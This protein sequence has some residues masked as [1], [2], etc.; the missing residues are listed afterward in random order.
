MAYDGSPDIV[1]GAPV[2]ETFAL[3][4]PDEVQSGGLTSTRGAN[5]KRMLATGRDLVKGMI[6]FSGIGTSE[7]YRDARTHYQSLTETTP[8][9]D[10]AIQRIFTDVKGRIME[11][12]LTEKSLDETYLTLMATKARTDASGGAELAMQK[13]F[14]DLNHAAYHKMFRKTVIWINMAQAFI[15]KLRGGQF[16]PSNPRDFQKAM[17]EAPAPKPEDTTGEMSNGMIPAVPAQSGGADDTPLQRLLD[18]VDDGLD[19]ALK[20]TV[21]R[22]PELER[23]LSEVPPAELEKAKADDPDLEQMIH[24]V[25]F[26]YELAPM[27]IELEIDDKFSGGGFFSRFTKKA[28][29]VYYPS[30][31]DED[32]DE[33]NPEDYSIEDDVTEDPELEGG[34]GFFRKLMGNARDNVKQVAPVKRFYG[35]NKTWGEDGRE[36][37]THY[38]LQ[39]NMRHD[40]I[41][42]I[43]ERAYSKWSPCF[44]ERKYVFKV[45]KKPEE[46]ETV[47][48]KLYEEK[49]SLMGSF[50]QGEFEYEEARKNGGFYTRPAKDGQPE[51]KVS[52]EEIRKELA[53]ALNDKNELYGF[54][55]NRMC[56]INDEVYHLEIMGGVKAPPKM[57][58]PQA[59]E[60]LDMIATF[61]KKLREAGITKKVTVKI[62][63]NGVDTGRTREEERDVFEGYQSL[64]GQ[65]SKDEYGQN[66]L[67]GG[68][69]FGK[70]RPDAIQVLLNAFVE[71]F[72]GVQRA[73]VI[74]FCPGKPVTWPGIWWLHDKFPVIGCTLKEGE[75]TTK[76]LINCIKIACPGCRIPWPPPNP[77]KGFTFC[78]PCECDCDA[79][80]EAINTLELA[81]WDRGDHLSGPNVDKF[82]KKMGIKPV[83][84]GALGNTGLMTQYPNAAAGI[85]MPTGQ[86]G[87][88]RPVGDMTQVLPAPA[89]WQPGQQSTNLPH[90]SGNRPGDAQA[91]Y[92][93]LGAPPAV[94]PSG[95]PHFSGNRP[96]DVQ[97]PYLALGQA[98]APLTLK[99][100]AEA[101]I[102]P[103]RIQT[104]PLSGT[105]PL[106]QRP[107]AAAGIDPNRAE[108][109][110]A[111]DAN[112]YI[113]QT[114]PLPSTAELGLAGTAP[115]PAANEL[116]VNTAPADP[117][118]TMVPMNAPFNTAPNPSRPVPSGSLRDIA[119]SQFGGASKGSMTATSIAL[120]A[121]ILA[122]AFLG[123]A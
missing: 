121:T 98:T 90:F 62:M 41:R 8:S 61:Q 17:A 44:P 6:P 53:S 99:P 60:Y 37:T 34:A 33:V 112:G 11:L 43:N 114:L 119:E 21:D 20:G 29:P 5:A 95:L 30:N 97:A 12:L 32:E 57:F 9:D 46:A 80:W 63:K 67:K 15:Y 28:A 123:A 83:P 111:T 75:K 78:P 54:G 73:R 74:G 93:A 3:E 42:L 50:A 77:F 52:A 109:L 47:F 58:T 10:I 89:G 13:N 108:T 91:P 104:V 102:D 100:S 94:D 71:C 36:T 45:S 22:R 18:F 55:W 14:F 48:H 39:P 68:L 76:N 27:K 92:L 4:D 70:M 79:M 88:T 19:N 25:R 107:P 66:E 120:G 85:G 51:R 65:W 1:D 2:D 26:N 106:T 82:L 101:G 81:L 23:L 56:R 122:M 113:I 31:E 87:P 103:N 7:H 84:Q 105:A 69:L 86:W 116:F 40:R 49:T 35:R 110:P 72:N 118:H 24:I 38:G 64:I 96:G 117:T 59:S 115:A 16:D